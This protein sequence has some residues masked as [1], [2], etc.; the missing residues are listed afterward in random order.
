MPQ[1]SGLLP[2]SFAFT[3]AGSIWFLVID[4]SFAELMFPAYFLYLSLV[5]VS[6][7]SSALS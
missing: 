5:I 1:S 4:V 7:D 3:G 6:C 2:M